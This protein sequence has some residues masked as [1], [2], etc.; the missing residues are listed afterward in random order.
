MAIDVLDT[1]HDALP[2]LLFGCYPYVTQHRTCKLG[3]ETLDEIEPGA[4]NGR[5]GK[6]EA[7]G[8]AS[9]EPGSAL[10]RDM[11]GMIVENKLDCG[12]GRVCAIKELQEFNELSAAVTIFPVSRSIPASR[13]SVPCRLYS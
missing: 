13:L 2:E 11:R 4:V 12:G 6:F 7:A 1:G 3:K 9:G 5:E 10:L 8:R